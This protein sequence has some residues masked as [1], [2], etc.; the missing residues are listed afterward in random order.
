[1]WEHCAV[2]FAAVGGAAALMAKCVKSCEVVAYE[3]LGTESIKRLVVE[4]MPLVVAID[5]LGCDLHDLGPERYLNEEN[6]RANY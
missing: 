3:E 1:M 2:Y 5:S 6:I 4:D